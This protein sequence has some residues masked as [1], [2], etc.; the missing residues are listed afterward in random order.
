[1]KNYAKVGAVFYALW[2]LLH[3]VGGLAILATLQTS[4][5]AG[6]SLFAATQADYPPLA[7][8][9]LGFHAFNIFWIGLLV[10]VIAVRLNWN[11]DRL[12]AYLNF[13]LAGCADLGLVVFL[14]AP[15]FVTWW[16]ASQGLGLFLVALVFTALGRF[17]IA[18]GRL[19]VGEA[20]M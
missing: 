14:L 11:N 2:G 19:Q 10:T 5:A 1:M 9:I 3:I 15:G 17:A 13:A 16:E 18:S 7:A 8:A 20:T 12:G 6:F 4:A